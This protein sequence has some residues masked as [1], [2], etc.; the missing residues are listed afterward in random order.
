MIIKHKSSDCPDANGRQPISGEQKWTLIF[1]LENGDDYLEIEMGK[2]GREAIIAMLKQEE[3][4]DKAGIEVY[5]R[6]ECPFHYCDVDYTH[7]PH[8]CKDANRCR[9]RPE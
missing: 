7:G 2:K 6:P 3:A 8:V 9:H 1:P 5:S 4:D